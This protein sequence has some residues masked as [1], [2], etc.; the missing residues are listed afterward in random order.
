[1][2]KA[3]VFIRKILPTVLTVVGAGST[4]AAVIF[5]AKEG[6]RYASIIED[7]RF[8]KC[9]EPSVKEK[10]LVGAKI[11]APAIG[12]AA[13]S[14]ACGV[15][16]HCLDLKTQANLTGAW[17]ASQQLYKKYAK[18]NEE[19]N[20]K[21]AD[22]KVREAIEEEKLTGAVRD[23][24]GEKLYVV[25]IEGL[26]EGGHRE[27]RTMTKADILTAIMRVNRMLD[28]IGCIT[29]NELR[30]MFDLAPVENGGDIGWSVDMLCDWCQSYQLDFSVDEMDDGSQLV[31]PMFCAYG[32]Y[33]TDYG[34]DY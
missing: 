12:C 3:G 26:E 7:K 23:A 20:G 13:V 4:I 33:L 22:E 19:L 10:V 18:K 24:D 15:G 31:Y 11:F 28:Q 34:L 6:P 9:E 25:H 30:G 29:L 32:G 16:A 21:A 1:M 27:T 8:E 5:A 14:I 17:V 2:S